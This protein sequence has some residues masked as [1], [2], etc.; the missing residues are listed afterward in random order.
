M[1][2]SNSS[3]M[4]YGKFLFNSI[5]DNTEFISSYKILIKNGCFDIAKYLPAMLVFLL[6]IIF[7]KLFLNY[8][9]T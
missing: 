3:K 4:M 8:L 1:L 9:F 2:Q 5:I 7:L 6:C